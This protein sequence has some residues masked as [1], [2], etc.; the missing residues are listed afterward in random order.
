MKSK[1]AFIKKKIREILIQKKQTNKQNKQ[2]TFINKSNIW[3][4]VVMVKTLYT[5]VSTLSPFGHH[6]EK[7][8]IIEKE[9][10]I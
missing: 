5:G 6:G 1:Q 2:S 8:K 3:N 9:S 7:K 10:V 4:L